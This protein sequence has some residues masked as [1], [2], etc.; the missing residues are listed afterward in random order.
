MTAAKRKEGYGTLVPWDFA[1]RIKHEKEI[2]AKR[3]KIEDMGADSTWS[4]NGAHC[5]ADPCALGF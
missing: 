1:F 4:E 3:R 5:T 2:A